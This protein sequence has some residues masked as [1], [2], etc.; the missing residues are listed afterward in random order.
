[1]F[2]RCPGLAIHEAVS[3]C[4]RFSPSGATWAKNDSV[5]IRLEYAVAA[6]SSA[7]FGLSVASPAAVRCSFTR[8]RVVATKA[9]SEPAVGTSS[10]P[11]HAVAAADAGAMP[12]ATTTATSHAAAGALRWRRGAAIARW[13]NV[14]MVFSRRS[15]W[16]WLL[17]HWI[18]VDRSA[19]LRTT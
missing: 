7:G 14:G 3:R 15:L 10:A 1:M 16:E 8:H 12:P 11:G 2:S 18:G 19:A 4:T 13:G 17:L 6:P 5:T 9:A